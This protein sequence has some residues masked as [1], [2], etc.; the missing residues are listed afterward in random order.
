[1]QRTNLR[2]TRTPRRTHARTHAH[3][4]EMLVSHQ[5]PPQVADR[6]T[7]V[8]YDG[9][10]GNKISGADQNLALTATQKTSEASSVGLGGGGGSGGMPLNKHPMERS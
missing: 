1:M 4:V 3:C 5:P 7:L 8:R 6:G 9:Y 2:H 10:R